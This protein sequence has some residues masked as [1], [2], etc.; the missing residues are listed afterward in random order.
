MAT[1][2]RSDYLASVQE[3]A[4]VVVEGFQPSAVDED[5][6]TRA[7]A[8]SVREAAFLDYAEGLENYMARSDVEPLDQRRAREAA[9]DVATQDFARADDYVGG[10]NEDQ[11]TVV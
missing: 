4:D 6:A 1:P 11:G 5:A 2:S 7:A 10:F 9:A 8:G 3:A